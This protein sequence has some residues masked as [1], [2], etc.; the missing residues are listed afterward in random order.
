MKHYY[1]KICSVILL[2]V[3]L[4][5][6]STQIKAQL[7][8]DEGFNTVLPTGW[9]QQNLSTPAGTNPVWFQ[10]NTAVFPAFSGP[11]TSYAACNFNSVAGANIISNWMFTPEVALANGNIISFYTR[12][13]DGTFPDRL[14]VR[15]STNGASVNVGAT[16]SSVGDYT[17]LLLTVNPSLTNTG[18]P[19]V[20]TKFTATISGLPAPTSGRF[21]FRYFVNN[22]GPDGSNSDFMG[23]DEVQYG[24]ACSG[25][26]TPGNTVSTVAST[27]PTVP[28]TLSLQNP[29]GGLGINYQW[30]SS[31]TGVAGSFTDIAGAT[32]AT[33]TTSLT[34]ATYYQAIVS[35]GANSTN[36]TPVQVGLLTCYCPA[37]AVSTAF[38]KISRVQFG[39]INNASTATAGYEDFTAISGNAYIGST[40]PITVTISGGFAADQV[41]VW[42]DFNKDFDFDDA[43]ELVYTSANGV[44]PHTGNIVIPGTVTTGSTRMRV[45]MHDSSL[46]ANGTPCGTSSYGQVEDYTVNLVPCVPTTLTAQPANASVACGADATFSVTLAGSDSSIVNWQYKTSAASTNWLD[47]SNAAPYSGVTT[48]MLTI[49]GATSNLNGY[50]YRV[51]YKGACTGTSFSGAATLTVNPLVAAVAKTPAGNICLGGIQQLSI[52]NT[53]PATV[54]TFSSAAALNITIPD[55]ASTTGVSNVIAVSGIPAGVIVTDIKI[56]MNLTHSWA[57]DMIV[58]A[59]APNNNVLN[60]AYALNGTGGAGATTG[61]QPTFAKT[62]TAFSNSGTNPYTGTFAADGYNATTGDPTV[63]TGPDGFIPT[64][65]AATRNTFAD[66]IPTAANSSTLNG[67]WTLAMY[68]YYD[69]FTTTNRFNNWSVEITYTG[70]LASGVWTSPTPN[71]LFTDAAATTPYDGVTPVNTL[72][73]LPTA[74]GVTNYTITVN[75]GICTSAPATVAVTANQ[76]ATSVSAVAN[77]IICQGGNATFTAAPVGGAGNTLQWQV[78]TDNGATYT[79]V[80]DGGVYSGAATGTLTVTGAGTSLNGYRYRLVASAAP[81]TGTVT[82]TAGILT[83]NPLPVLGLT[84]TQSTLYPGQ[85]ATL[86]VTSSTTVPAGG[87]TWYR[88]GVIVPGA[89]GNT[90]VVDVDGLGEYTVTAADANGCGSAQPASVTITDAANDILFIYPSPNTGVFQVRYYSAAGNNPL[91]RTIN[92]YDSKGARVYS[93]SYSVAVP[94]TRM[95]VDMSVGFQKGIYQVELTDRSGNRLKT[96]RVLIL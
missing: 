3:V 73:A 48:R 2:L 87:Y 31:P 81:C 42:I 21:A 36:S 32:N 54:V 30:Q 16:N 89:T 29:P 11:A 95:D 51:V 76:L 79:N 59:K 58:V 84:T 10:G 12:T 40:M 83:V 27:C 64:S 60:L 69:D 61:F 55:D 68:D 22:G 53:Q 47:L 23:V 38:E 88:N 1:K 57:G 70:G 74:A 45:R 5:L 19:T 33:L 35:C 66:L 34:A 77:S 37:G 28:F 6:T 13:T 63:P 8:I 92:I 52:T 80:T 62:G 91:P 46:G 44:G 85:T 49:T 14:E 18:Y 25:T 4:G 43:G 26:P 9:A 20:W 56:K 41:K 67:N 17:T 24:V 86:T 50:Q 39:S 90:L 7:L 96:G 78:S 65:V 75:N 94:Y 72:Y 71:S 15:M 82:S 93:K